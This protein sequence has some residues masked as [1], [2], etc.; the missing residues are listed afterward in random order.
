MRL[1]D[2]YPDASFP[3]TDFVA[4][5]GEETIERVYRI[6]HQAQH[7]ASEG[8]WFWS[9]MVS[10]PGLSF[11]ARSGTEARQAIARAEEILHAIQWPTDEASDAA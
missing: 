1:S 11:N 10:R 9:M 8:H 3:D 2:V 6:A 4:L 7:A 5:D